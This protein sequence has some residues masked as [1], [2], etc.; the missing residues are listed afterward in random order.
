MGANMFFKYVKVGGD[1]RL[2]G[3]AYRPHLPT[4][5]ASS[6][7]LLSTWSNEKLDRA[8]ELGVLNPTASRQDLDRFGKTGSTA[9]PS[10]KQEPYLMQIPFPA[11]LEQIES[12]SDAVCQACEKFEVSP[13]FP[14]EERDQTDYVRW[15]A[16][17]NNA[18]R[19]E[20]DKLIEQ[21]RKAYKAKHHREWTYGHGDDTVL[22]QDADE[23]KIRNALA[24]IGREDEFA[25]LLEKV[26]RKLPEPSLWVPPRLQP[27]PVARAPRTRKASSKNSVTAHAVDVEASS[28]PSVRSEASAKRID[29]SEVVAAAE[30]GR[31]ED[32]STQREG[33]TSQQF[34][35]R[36]AKEG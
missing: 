7:H 4:H 3:E 22:D 9:K 18:L 2:N 25:R 6:L 35:D 12:L 13:H 34:F 20:A 8:I 33:E 5:S 19:V 24:L 1:M 27:K 10:E 14:A 31:A 11:T 17:S 21:S 29:V 23:Q 30:A 26:R 36:L 15:V 32:D 16:K 28:G